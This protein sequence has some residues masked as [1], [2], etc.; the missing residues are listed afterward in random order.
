MKQPGRQE[1]LVAMVGNDRR[2]FQVALRNFKANLA[3]QIQVAPERKCPVYALLK[4]KIR[5]HSQ[6]DW[7]FEAVNPGKQ[8]QVL[9]P[10][11]ARA[12]V[13]AIIIQPI[14]R[15]QNPRPS[16][17][18]PFAALVVAAVARVRAAVAA[19]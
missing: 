3:T 15:S 6:I 2:T 1:K 10:P 7:A 16:I 12:V 11:P 8:R 13:P 17:G 18:R 14:K 19:A 9:A 5:V 4:S